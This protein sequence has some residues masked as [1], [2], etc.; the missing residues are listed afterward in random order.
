MTLQEG[1]DIRKATAKVTWWG[2]KDFLEFEASPDSSQLGMFRSTCPASSQSS[3]V[4]H[5]DILDI[6]CVL[7]DI[8][9]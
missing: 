2:P 5:S 8:T 6:D 9:D 7:V 4:S 1:D 3:T